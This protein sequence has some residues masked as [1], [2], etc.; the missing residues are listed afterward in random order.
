MNDLLSGDVQGIV[1]AGVAVYMVV[2]LVVG[3]VAARR[4]HSTEDFFVAGRTMPLW[5]CSTSV[6]ATWIGGGIVM[7][8]AGAAYEGGMLAVIADPWG[9]S[10][11]LLLVGLLVITLMRRL[12]FYTFIEFIEQRFGYTAGTLAALA[13]C[14]G[15]LAWAGALMVA[16]GTVTHAITGLPQEWGIIIGAAIMLT[17]TAIGGMWAVA[18]TDF[19]QIA[20]IVIGLAILLAVVVIDVGGIGAAWAAIPAEKLRMTPWDNQ[21]ESWLNYLRA[22]FI[23][24]ISN[25]GAQ[26][27][28]QRGLSARTERIARQSFYISS[29]GYLAIGLVP[30]IL[31]I[32]AA[33]L[34]PGLDEKESVIPVMAAEYMHPVLLAVFVGALLAAIMSSADSAML[35]ASSVITTNI[36]PRFLGQPDPHRHLRWVRITIP[37]GGILAVVIALKVR[38]V[39]ELIQ[40]ANVV[41]LAAVTGPFVVALWWPRTN[42]MGG[43]WGMSAGFLAWL[44]IELLW[45]GLPGDLLGLVVSVVTTVLVSLRTQAS[46]PPRP[47]LDKEGH[48]VNTDDLPGWSGRSAGAKSA[49]KAG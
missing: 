8:A 36:L 41:P 27:L 14:I 42:R 43:I 17:Y 6:M 34:M 20:I 24:G 35:S 21:P 13:N 9:A 29:V 4:N 39:Y 37:V 28:I 23:I 5:L 26:S 12:R 11:G 1:L 32:L 48:P 7:G 25:L 44:G 49:K 31:G 38:T 10:L 40:W 47:L 19:V 15:S 16:F 46:C 30:V 3:L 33:Q 22:W 45:P 18:M 2:M